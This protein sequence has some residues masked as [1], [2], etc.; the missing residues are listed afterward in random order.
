MAHATSE[1]KHVHFQL[2]RLTLW[3]VLATMLVSCL[4]L[5]TTS[6]HP[7]TA[8][9]PSPSKAVA[10]QVQE[11]K[12]DRPANTDPFG[13][14]VG[15]Q[16][17]VVA[18][19]LNCRATPSTTGTIVSTESSG[20]LGQIT[21][22]SVSSGG[23][24]WWYIAYTDGHTGWSAEGTGTTA[25][26]QN[27]TSGSVAYNRSGAMYYAEHYWNKVTSDGYFWY[28]SG[29]YE[30]F[31]QGTSVIGLSGDDCAH[32]VS[33][34][35]GNQANQSG[36]GL[37]IPSRVPPTYGEPA[38][39]ALGD[40]LINNGWATAVSSVSQLM[41]GDAINYEWLSTDGGWDHIAVYLGN[42]TVAAHTTSHFGA[43]WTLGG[44][45][46]YRFIH[47]LNSSTVGGF[48]ISSFSASPNPITV[49]HTTYLNASA[50][51]GTMPYTYS[52]TALPTG[53]TTAST[54]SLACT[55]TVPGTFTVHVFVN[56]SAAHT[57]TTTTTLTV[58]AT[59]I[60]LSSITLSPTSPSV[61]GGATQA[62]TV[63]PTCSATCPG[64][65][66]YSW[67]L[68]SST[69]GTLTGSGVSM[70]FTAGFTAGTIGIYA[71]ATLSGTTKGASTIVTVAINHLVS[72]ALSPTG[73]TIASGNYQIFT[74][75][76]TCNAIC[77]SG[78]VYA[79]TITN[80]LLGSLTG[81][82]ASVNFTA[83]TSGGTLGIFINV[84]LNGVTK[85]EG[86]VITITAPPS[87]LESL[88]LSP[89][90]PTLGV[91]NYTNLT[92]T[93]TCN[94]T[95]QASSIAYVWSLSSSS[96]G[97]LTGSGPT[98]LFT[99]KSV[100]GIDGIFVNASLNGVTKMASGVITVTIPAAVTLASVALSPVMPTVAASN[101]LLFTATPTCSSACPG[102][103]AYSWSLT[104]TSL[105]AL[106]SSGS[107]NSFNAGTTA[108]TV[109]IFVNATL[110]DTTVGTSTV[111]AVTASS[112]PVLRSI[113]VSPPNASLSPGGS[114]SFTV[115]PTC[116]GG[117]CP[118]TISYA[119]TL[120]DSLGNLSQSSGT[121]NTFTAGSGMGSVIMEVTAT[122]NGVYVTASVFI[123]ISP[124][125]SH[126]AG[127]WSFSL[128]SWS[129]WIVVAVAVVVAGAVVA[130]LVAR[131][132]RNRASA[133]QTSAQVPGGSASD[134]S[135]LPE[136]PVDPP[137]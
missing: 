4:A 13:L 122:M 77:P 65:I 79:W 72:V 54:A 29:S 78:A 18:T 55:P 30:H 57:A 86:T 44:A 114:Q 53:C 137:G 136:F 120:S 106:G 60:T 94:P 121:S 34:V 27:V 119:W 25:W 97:S 91:L 56:D 90:A 42:G 67:A 10:T 99:A 24:V 31:A 133:L 126:G 85:G 117:A 75:T 112:G 64:G 37:N 58:S 131:R 45:Y 14:A 43:N 15:D 101:S 123:T 98:V 47:I 111:I 129:T 59:A 46:A 71:N 113:S 28:S 70:I 105:G 76:P 21:N 95:C 132:G 12:P 63:T 40:L 68:T 73:P 66:T 9:G 128:S 52:Y 84:S 39:G 125:T 16:V 69:M 107:T 17:Q 50:I 61:N 110:G 74:A 102:T 48:S 100:A 38:A 81:N 108:G 19:S 8:A 135:E 51:G 7:S 5:V 92:A 6:L 23:Y 49:S 118:T 82:G 87:T 26:L 89:S 96:L 62:F 33:Q 88:S 116:T 115:A 22:G 36:G 127:F 35:I 1:S 41:A 124:Q 104:S 80:G 3:L 134:P 20:Q 83:G 130:V 109:G 32:F 2:N 93:P 11:R 103:I